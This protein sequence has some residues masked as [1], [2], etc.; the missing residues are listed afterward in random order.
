MEIFGLKPVEAYRTPSGRLMPRSLILHR[1]ANEQGS[2]L[3]PTTAWIVTYHGEAV[4]GLMERAEAVSY[5]VD[6]IK[7][8]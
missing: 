5:L 8:V 2:A 1:L 4:T 7:S 6:L 3:E